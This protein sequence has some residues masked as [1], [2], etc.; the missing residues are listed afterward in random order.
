MGSLFNIVVYSSDSS[1]AVAAAAQTYLMI[2]TLNT[3]Y[4]D[5]LP[6]SELNRLSA[7]SGTGEWVKVSLPLY[8]ILSAAYKASEVSEGSFDVTMGPLTKLWR[9]ARQRKAMPHRDSLADAKR[10]VG[11]RMME[12]S[13]LKQSIRLKKTGM[14]LDLGGIAK[15][16]TAQRAVVRLRELGFPY[17]LVDAGGDIVAGSVPPGIEGWVVSINLAGSEDVMTR[18]LLLKNK[19]VTTSGDIYQYVELNGRR[20]SHII[21]PNTGYA[22]TNSRNVTVISNTGITADWLTKACS[23]LPA[24]TALQLVKRFPFTEVQIAMLK[25]GKPAYHRSRGFTAYFK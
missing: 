12:F 7:K 11:F 17:A 10:R 19:A 4:S 14:Q 3:I 9:M 8:N 21:N 18:Q 5:Y 15:G 20:F 2:D 23:V 22:L 25:N 13:P 16:E 6:G 1:K 24:E